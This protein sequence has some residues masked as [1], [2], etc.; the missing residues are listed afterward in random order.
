MNLTLV[1]SNP[2]QLLHGYLATHGLDRNCGSIGSVACDWLLQDQH[3]N[4]RPHHCH[5]HWRENHFCVT[6]RCGHTYAN[7][8]D[9][10]L[11]RETM[12]YLH[13]GD[14]LQMGD[15]QVLVQLRSQETD[16][17]DVRHP[18]QRSVTELLTGRRDGWHDWHPELLPITPAPN[19]LPHACTE[20]ERLIRPLDLPEEGDPLL[21]L[22]ALM[23]PTAVDVLDFPAR[24]RI[25]TCTDKHADC[26]ALLRLSR[27]RIVSNFRLAMLLMTCLILGGCTVLGKVGQVIRDPSIPVGGPEDQPSH[28]S[29]S[30]HASDHVN[31]RLISPGTALRDPEDPTRS[32][33]KVNVQ[34][35]S[36]L[37]LTE[38][39][40][41]VLDHLYETVPA[42]SPIA[43]QPSALVEISPIEDALLGDYEAQ[44]VSLSTPLHDTALQQLATPIAFKVLQLTDDSLLINATFEDL[45]RDLKKT[46]GSTYIHVDD[47]LLQPGQFK[48]VDLRALNEDTRFIAV[49]ANYYSV[50]VARWKQLLRVEPK[51]RQYALLVQ[52]GDSQVDL[53]GE[54][55]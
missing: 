38:K 46:L 5:I 36:P 13:E 18:S 55:R 27:S 50:D 25:N 4:V 19:P 23:P 17:D 24:P 43:P 21:A 33:Y 48:F 12:V 2:A 32:H 14:V 51:G 3:H 7:G 20:F 47:Y 8:H 26:T 53:K 30:L 22:E 16:A 40:Q 37:A 45:N 6:D 39:L 34:A 49:I 42:H 28:Y 54:T 29:L 10:P 15:Y 9:L 44:G 35:N 1:I 41:T 11:G 52:L 31:P